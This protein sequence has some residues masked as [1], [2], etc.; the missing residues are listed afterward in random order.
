MFDPTSPILTFSG[1]PVT[2]TN[3]PR[4]LYSFCE[5]DSDTESNEYG[6]PMTSNLAS[7]THHSASPAPSTCSNWRPPRWTT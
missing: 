3:V 6:E 5:A 1:L 2:P 4:L 7:A